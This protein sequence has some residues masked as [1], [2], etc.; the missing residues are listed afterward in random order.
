MKNTPLVEAVCRNFKKWN[1]HPFRVRM[2][3]SADSGSVSM[4]LDER[5]A[6][7]GVPVLSM[8]K[9]K[10]SDEPIRFVRIWRS[11]G[12]WC[13]CVNVTPSMFVSLASCN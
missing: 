10:K 12:R 7:A 2:D 5:G 3:G 6:G 11:N 4:D 9:E 8:Q 1:I 13:C